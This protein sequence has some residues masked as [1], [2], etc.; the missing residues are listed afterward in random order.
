MSAEL[1]YIVV[2]IWMCYRRHDIRFAHPSV[3]LHTAFI[4]CRTKFMYC[5]NLANRL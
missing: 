2:I 1:T 5:E 3:A 4:A